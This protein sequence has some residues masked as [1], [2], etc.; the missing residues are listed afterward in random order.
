MVKV[1]V[2]EGLTV[3]VINHIGKMAEVKH[4]FY[5]IFKNEGYPDAFLFGEKVSGPLL[6]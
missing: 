6:S 3:R 5:D 2:P 1:Q 4:R